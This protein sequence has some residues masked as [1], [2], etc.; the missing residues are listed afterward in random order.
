MGLG[1]HHATADEDALWR[2]RHDQKMGQLRESVCDGIPHRAVGLQRARWLAASGLDGGAGRQAFDA[3]AV[4]R[5]IARPGVAAGAHE[6]RVADLGMMAVRRRSG[7]PTMSP[8][9]MPVPTVI[10]A[11]SRQSLRVAPA[12][13][14]QCRAD[15]VRRNPHG[16][17][18]SPRE[19]SGD[20][21]IG[22]ASFRGGAH[23]AVGWRVSAQIDRS[24]RGDAQGIRWAA[25]L[26]PLL[27]DRRD[28][29]ERG[30]GI[31]CGRVTCARMSSGPV[32]SVQTHLVPPISMPASSVVDMVGV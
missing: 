4:E 21:R 32:P 5:A 9:P 11:K 19:I 22:P 17:R 25:L 18:E 15:D 13:F 29:V 24:E 3:V 7:P 1:A 8:A 26:A 31:E 10:Y 16:Q 27:N 12:A 30:V 6:A 20:I 2:D 14:G 28:R 23:A